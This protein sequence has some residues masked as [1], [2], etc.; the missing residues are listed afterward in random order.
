MD[1][2]VLLKQLS[3]K[4]GVSGREDEIARFLSA[5]FSAFG[6]S[7][8]SPLGSVIGT[9]SPVKEGEDHLILVAHMDEVGFVVTYIED[10]GFVRIGNCGGI[11]RKILPSAIMTIHT[12]QGDL[13]GVVSTIPPHLQSGDQSKLPKVEE[14]SID[15]GLSGEEAK[16]RISLG[17]MVTIHSN[18]LS[19]SDR[20]VSGKALD[21]RACCAAILRACELLQGEPLRK[22]VSVV[23][24]TM[25]EVGSQGAKTAAYELAPTHAVALDVSYGLSADAKRQDCGL[26]GKGPMIGISPVLDNGMFDTLKALGDEQK[27]PYQI[28][29]MG[30][31]TGTDADIIATTRDGVRTALISIPLRY[32]HSPVETVLVDDVEQSARLLA[33]Y[34]REFNRSEGGERR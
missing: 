28:E 4:T 19:L 29:V 1:L 23:F 31:R 32:M 5:Q 22:G 10:S 25:E 15:V 16:K 33:A 24:S 3:G 26:I 8:V 21:D 14:I 11:D 12:K 13:N 27:I 34:V 7:R 2:S 20:F 17:D 9:L 18:A 30:G 6:P